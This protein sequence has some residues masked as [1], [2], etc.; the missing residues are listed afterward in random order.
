M[1]LPTCT[2]LPSAALP[3]MEP[4]PRISVSQKNGISFA[5]RACGVSAP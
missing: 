4:C 5:R 2:R 3:A 1:R